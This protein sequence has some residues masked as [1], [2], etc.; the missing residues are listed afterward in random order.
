[1]VRPLDLQDNFSKF[2]LLEKVH[3]VQRALPQIE[4]DTFIRSMNQQ[5]AEKLKKAQELKEAEK[6]IIRDRQ[7]KEQKRNKRRKD[8][9]NAIAAQ[10]EEDS[11]DK[12]S[13]ND[14]PRHIDI[15]V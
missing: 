10:H 6:G 3:E 11:Q 8:H 13:E 12:K 4:H 9:M 5:L 7:E 14:S 1:M 15:L 2:P